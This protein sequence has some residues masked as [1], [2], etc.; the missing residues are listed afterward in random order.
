MEGVYYLKEK[1]ILLQTQTKLAMIKKKEKKK[2][3]L[4]WYSSLS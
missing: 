2:K 3:D 4:R 1:K